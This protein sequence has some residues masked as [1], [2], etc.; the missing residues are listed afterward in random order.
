MKNLPFTFL[1]CAITLSAFAQPKFATITGPEKDHFVT[2]EQVRPDQVSPYSGESVP[3]QKSYDNSII[4]TTWYDL[5]SYTNVMQRI[6]AYPD[7]TIG[8]TWMSAGQN[9]VPERGT[10]YNYFDGNTWGTA[11]LHVGPSN[12]MGWP[13][14]APWGPNGEIIAQYRYV[15]GEGPIQF[16][17]REN[18]GQGD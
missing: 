8:A 12:R 1:A 4:G 6:W 13:S 9:L 16:Y 10:G 11:N 14:Y 3:G 2:Q 17:K 5:Q 15:A 7:G 18:K